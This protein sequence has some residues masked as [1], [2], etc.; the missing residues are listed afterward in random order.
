MTA[1]AVPSSTKWN[2]KVRP[3]AECR[4]R[5][6]GRSRRR[7]MLAATVLAGGLVLAAVLVLSPTPAQAKTSWELN[8]ELSQTR[9]RLEQVRSSIQE[10]EAV[11]LAAERDVAGLDRKIELLQEKLNASTEARDA[12]AAN[13][14]KTR[15]ALD[16]VRYELATKRTQFDKAEADLGRANARLEARAVGIYK[17]GRMGYM[18]MLLENS[19]LGDLLTRVDFLTKVMNQDI[20]VADAAAPQVGRDHILAGV[21]P[22]P[23][24]DGLLERPRSKL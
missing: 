11:R 17:T 23:A 5:V 15:K 24:R 6:S 19:D 1:K 12:A 2:Q 22:P 8:E 14:A 20:Q 3:L 18:L 21:Q 4:P 13:L 7:L 9:E 16:K 10:A